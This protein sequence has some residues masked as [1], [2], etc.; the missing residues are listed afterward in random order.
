MVCC[1]L[2]L[3]IGQKTLHLLEAELTAILVVKVKNGMVTGCRLGCRVTD[4]STSLSITNFTTVILQPF[5]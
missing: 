4:Y 5:F 1:L 2:L 3:L